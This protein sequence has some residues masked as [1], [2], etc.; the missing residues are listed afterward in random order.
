MRVFRELVAADG[1]IVD[2]VSASTSIGVRWVV[3]PACSRVNLNRFGSNGRDSHLIVLGGLQLKTTGLQLKTT[4]DSQ[5]RYESTIRVQRC[6][7]ELDGDMY[8]FLFTCPLLRRG[9][10]VWRVEIRRQQSQIDIC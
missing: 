3:H 10:H 7:T 8:E 4:K 1:R 6:E 9:M 5:E 2:V